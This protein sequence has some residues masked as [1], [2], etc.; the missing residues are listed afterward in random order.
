MEFFKFYDHVSYCE[1]KTVR[2]NLF[3]FLLLSSTNP[4]DLGSYSVRGLNCT[5]CVR[6][7][8]A[9]SQLIYLFPLSVTKIPGIANLT[10]QWAYKTFKAFAAPFFEEGLR[11]T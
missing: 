3:S 4:F 11:T 6:Q 8:C 1:S 5:W 10:I 7:K 2:K 9:C